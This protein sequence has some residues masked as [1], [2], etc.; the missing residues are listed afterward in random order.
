ME[1]IKHIPLKVEYPRKKLLFFC[2]KVRQQ[3]GKT[4]RKAAL[5]AIANST[6]SVRIAVSLY[7]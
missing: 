4:G 2:G 3:S 1:I 7:R 6:I 5:F